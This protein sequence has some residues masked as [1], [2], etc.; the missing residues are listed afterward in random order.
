[1][2][3][4]ATPFTSSGHVLAAASCPHPGRPG[5]RWSAWTSIK[6]TGYA[7][8]NIPG[9]NASWSLHWHAIR[10]LHGD[11]LHMRLQS[12]DGSVLAYKSYV[13]KYIAL[14]S[15]HWH[16]DDIERS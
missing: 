14:L 5:R 4:I 16:G 3:T 1:M 15:F 13:K 8:L 12:D 10:N 7:S 2:H 11:A 6:F 9:T